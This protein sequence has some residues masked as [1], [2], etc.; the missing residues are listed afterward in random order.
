MAAAASVDVG[1]QLD[2]ERRGAVHALVVGRDG[3]CVGGGGRAV[4]RDGRGADC[5]RRLRA[6]V[7][8]RVARLLRRQH[9]RRDQ[10]AREVR[11]L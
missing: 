5:A 2:D 4:Y 6:V 10:A 8:G 11:L 1:R 3:G 9:Q 7:D